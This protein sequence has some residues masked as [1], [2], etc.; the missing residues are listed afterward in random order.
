M[1]TRWLLCV[2]G[3]SLVVAGI[4]ARAEMYKYVD[5]KGRLHFTQDIGQVPP[6][7]RHQ[8]EKKVLE[9]DISV[10]GEG[11]F[12][13]NAK[14]LAEIKKRSSE[15]KRIVRPVR[16]AAAPPAKSQNRLTGAPEPNK[17]DR[18][19]WWRGNQKRCK[20]WVT[21]EWLAWNAANGGDNGKAVTRWK[22]GGR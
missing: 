9:R 16:P 4:P 11:E 20:K 8:V 6:E 7:Y 15:L 3:V 5:S 17:Y 1:K 19:C 10:T 18:E 2:A 13:D 14:R 21:R 22:I 12:G